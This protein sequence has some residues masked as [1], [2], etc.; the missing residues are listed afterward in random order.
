MR[1]L[2]L[3][4]VLDRENCNVVFEFWGG[5]GVLLFFSSFGVVAG[6]SDGQGVSFLVVC[7]GGVVWLGYF[8]SF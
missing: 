5:F 3:F 4:L 1:P 6:D 2:I 8:V 7:D